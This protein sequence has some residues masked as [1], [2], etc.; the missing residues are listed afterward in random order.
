MPAEAPEPVNG[1]CLHQL[2]ARRVLPAPISLRPAGKS[3]WSAFTAVSGFCMCALLFVF[4]QKPPS[5]PGRQRWV[6]PATFLQVS[7]DRTES[8]IKGQSHKTDLT[9]VVV[10][11]HC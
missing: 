2:P 10:G 6:C 9:H 4:Q 3:S 8:G 11:A 7:R 5:S 1:N